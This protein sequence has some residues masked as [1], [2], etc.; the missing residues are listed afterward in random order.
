VRCIQELEAVLQAHDARAHYGV[1]V[2]TIDLA[3]KYVGIATSILQHPKTLLHLLDEALVLAQE[4]LV[5][6]D[7][8]YTVKAFVHARLHALPYFLDPTGPSSNPA[9]SCVGSGHQDRLLTVAGT[10]VRAQG[11]QL[12]EAYRAMECLKCKSLVRVN[13]SVADPTVV[14][15]PEQCPNEACA[16]SSFR[17]AEESEP[18]Y[19]NYQEISI[20]AHPTHSENVPRHGRELAASAVWR[21]SPA[22]RPRLATKL[23]RNWTPQ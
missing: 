12:F 4:Q 5:G 3:H 9:L 14:N 6:E 13:V 15:V 20:Q 23:C 22:D 18:G 11:V 16:S 2:S 19:T 21:T 17:K 8:N 1:E 7:P 10:V